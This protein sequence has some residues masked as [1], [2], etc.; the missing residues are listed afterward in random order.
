MRRLIIPLVGA[1][2]SAVALLG[3]TTQVGATGSP[4]PNTNEVAYWCPNGGVKYDNLNSTTFTV[5]APPAGKVWTLLVLKAGSDQ[6]VENENE[7]FPNPVVGQA[8]SHSSGKTLSHAILCQGYAPTTTTGAT[9]TAATTTL[10]TTTTAPTTTGATT[11]FCDEDECVT[12]TTGATTTA[13][14]T[15]IATTTT[16]PTTT[17][18]TT[19][20][21]PV[22]TTAPFVTNPCPGSGCPQTTPP[23]TVATTVPAT[24]VPVTTAPPTSA[25]P[26]TTVG[27]PT[28]ALV[29]SPPTELP[30][31]GANYG[32]EIAGA[33]LL[34]FLGWGG[35]ALKHSTR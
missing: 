21:L 34:I 28:P 4:P 20:T 23:T 14:T 3:F 27:T 9:T 35:L 5:P 2:L 22:T 30:H 6:S 15:T 33:F 19:T 10:A 26:V 16:A 11:T 32:A 24:T 1:A 13:A 25:A 31:T 8:Y 29:T 18:G 7:T 12:T 17:Q